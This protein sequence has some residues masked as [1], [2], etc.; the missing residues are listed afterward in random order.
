MQS[1]IR[2]LEDELKEKEKELGLFRDEV[3][4]LNTQLEMLIDQTG[5]EVSLAN[6]IHK[7]L[8]P[9]E[10]PN[11]PG[12][13]F[14]SKYEASAISG[15]DYF[16]IFELEDRYR[17]GILLSCSSGYGM[18]AVLLSILMKLSSQME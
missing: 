15:G 11:I 4:K 1:R 9:T 5:L 10:I 17:F 14:S 12:F 18:S 16:D 8:V 7:F 13:D 6:S 3:S 2:D